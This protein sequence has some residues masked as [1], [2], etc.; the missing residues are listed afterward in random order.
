MSHYLLL[1]TG[2]SM[3]TTDADRKKANDEW[4]AWYKKLDK[5]VIDEGLP[6]TPLAKNISADGRVGDG[7]I[8]SLASGYTIIQ[9]ISL[10]QAVQIAKGCPGLKNGVRISVYETLST[11]M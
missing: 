2:G 3:A 5:T 11:M 8:G 9:A 1:Y 7:P 6:F 4:N 10:D